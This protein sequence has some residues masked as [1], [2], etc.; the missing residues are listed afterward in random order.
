MLLNRIFIGMFLVGF[1]MAA[2]KLLFWSDMNI[3]KNMV[4]A[5]FSAAKSG[6]ELA[7]FLTG[8]LCLWMGFMRI[9]EKG[10]AVQLLS[11]A[12]S[13]LFKRLF[14]EIPAGHPAVGSIMMNFSA[15]MLGLDN[16]ATPLGLKAMTEL[17][18]LNPEKET[19]SN[20]QI[21]FLVLN[22]SGLTLIPVSILAYRSAAGSSAP[23]EVF[24]PI[25]LATFCSTLIGMT[26]VAIRQ[27]INL[28]HPVIL[29]YLVGLL[30]MVVGLLY[31]VSVHPEYSDAISSV[32]GNVMLIG[33]IALFFILAMRKKVNVYDEFIEGAKGGF[34]VAI[35]VIPYLVAML[36]ALSVFR[37]SGAL[38]GVLD[39]VRWLFI[40]AGI[41]TVE[42]I[43]ALPV[44]LMKPFS[45][46]G[47]RALMLEAFD[48]YGVDSFRGKVAATFQGS[49]ETTF[50]V[51]AVY[52]GSVGIKNTRYAAGAG[53]I[54]DL[55][56]I[57]AAI[58][59]SYLFYTVN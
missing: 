22:T 40:T 54:A 9:G 45:G 57:I 33:I 21:M 7:I 23:S 15:N 30:A 59:I 35:T 2:G 16:A 18:E 1:A 49:T 29:S 51:L 37:A 58:F 36:A 48:Q 27:K 28:F 20:A 39:G 34:E 31:L 8:A 26:F 10:G 56:G 53:L 32:G 3:F 6:F 46:S 44:A 17:Q 4:D 43:D 12:V 42:F 25:L 24:L 38:E 14:P 41:A 11:K 47:A 5:L 55:A 52:F 13:P 50:Y 19:A